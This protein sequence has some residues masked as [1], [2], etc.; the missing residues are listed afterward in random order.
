MTDYEAF[1]QRLQ[2]RDIRPTAMRIRVLSYLLKSKASIS[3][4]DLEE[5]FDRADRTTL[6]RTLKTFEEKRLIHRIVD[7]TGSSR[8]AL[9]SSD[10]QCSYPADLHPHFFC[11]RC[12]DVYCLTDYR[13]PEF[14]VPD[15]FIAKDAT[16]LIKGICGACA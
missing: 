12:E 14:N 15:T 8:Y 2:A 13:L 10:C 9:C 11:T 4:G 7:D 5:F 1:E 16:Y 3:L 6:Y